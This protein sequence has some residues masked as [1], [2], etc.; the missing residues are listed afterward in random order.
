MHRCL[1][2]AVNVLLTNVMIGSMCHAPAAR[3]ILPISLAR[4]QLTQSFSTRCATV[5]ARLRSIQ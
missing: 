4:I 2:Q 3:A 1:C 5:Y